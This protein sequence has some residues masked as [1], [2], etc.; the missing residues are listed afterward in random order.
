MALA[1]HERQLQQRE[2]A[3]R[4]LVA[5]LEKAEGAAARR[6]E[7]A[8]RTDEYDMFEEYEEEDKDV[9]SQSL[10][11]E[12]QALFNLST[13]DLRSALLR[14]RRVQGAVVKQLRK[15]TEDERTEKEE[16]VRT[17]KVAQNIPTSFCFASL[18][19]QLYF[20]HRIN[21]F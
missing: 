21:L 7:H 1:R 15:D 6:E 13:R 16:T 3:V 17:F 8:K 18:L 14:E 11:S 12:E 9:D 20:Y 5:D 19:I 10:N 2:E 4:Q